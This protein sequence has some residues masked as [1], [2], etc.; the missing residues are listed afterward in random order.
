[1]QRISRRKLLYGSAVAGFG[2]ALLA[3]CGQGMAPATAPADAPAAE[4]E[5]PQA[6]ESMSMADGRTIISFWSYIGFGSTGLH[7]QVQG[8]SDMVV[9]YNSENEDNILVEIVPGKG[10]DEAK[11]A[12]AGGVPPAVHWHAWPDSTN[13]FAAGV[14]VDHEEELKRF[15]GWTEQR[16]DYFEPMTVSTTWQGKLTGL[17]INTNNNIM[18]WNPD[19]L[20]T[21]G[22]S[23]PEEGWTWDDMLEMAQKAA[24]PPEVWGWDYHPRSI[25]RWDQVAGS[26]GFK[27]LNEE[28]T[29]WNFD[30]DEAIWATQM[31]SDWM[32]AYQLAPYKDEWGGELFH[33]GKTVFESQGPYRLPTLRKRGDVFKAIHTPIQTKRH[34]PNGGQNIAVFVQANAD[35]LD[36]GLRFAQYAVSADAQVFVITASGGTNLP[37]SKSV[38]NHEGYQGLIAN[39][40][41]YATF[42]AELPNGGRY[43]G[44]P[45]GYGG[46]QGQLF[47]EGFHKVWRG[48]LTAEEGMK[49]IQDI[50][51]V[52]LE[53]DIAR[54]GG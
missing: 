40:P 49:V 1:M 34:A 48:E 30:S 32:N 45:S 4:D 12:A 27:W 21:A 54:M 22:V 14:T 17:P 25:T 7:P 50:A 15:P 42:A 13:F 41:D 33:D 16:A 31:I 26:A 9:K 6:E 46:F 52:Q 5:A 29:R 51:Q 23:D 8:L 2:S 19:I 38:L 20:S 47:S 18:I 3:A 44:L 43:P 11:T 28:Q 35:I 53:A 36:A 39:D 24:N 37:V 10:T